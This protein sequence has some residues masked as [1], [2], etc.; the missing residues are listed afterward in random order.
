MFI[1]PIIF[2]VKFLIEAIKRNS[3]ISIKTGILY[4]IISSIPL[5][6]Y[7]ILWIYYLITNGKKIDLNDKEYIRDVNDCYPPAITGLI[8]DMKI[9]TYKD[10]TATFL[11]LYVKKYIDITNPKKRCSG[12]FCRF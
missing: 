2:A 1:I 7:I 5:A 8:E 4:T 11:N 9:F 10:Y 3:D 6:V 12:S